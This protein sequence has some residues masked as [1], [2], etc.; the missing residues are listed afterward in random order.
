MD[1]TIISPLIYDFEN[2]SL[3][4]G[5]VETYIYDLAHILKSAKMDVSIYQI[6]NFTKEVS[7]NGVLIKSYLLS[8]MEKEEYFSIIILTIYIQKRAIIFGYDHR[9]KGS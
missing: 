1:V 2:Y 4:I 3:K 5:G 7:L 8:R 9:H 6:D